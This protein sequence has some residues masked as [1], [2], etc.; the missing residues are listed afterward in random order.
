[1]CRLF[2]SSVRQCYYCCNPWILLYYFCT[3]KQKERKHIIFFNWQITFINLTPE[4]NSM[5][6]W[7]HVISDD[8][9]TSQRISLF[10]LRFGIQ[11]WIQLET[12]HPLS[13]CW[14]KGNS[15]KK[16]EFKP[17][18]M[19]GVSLIN[20]DRWYDTFVEPFT[21]RWFYIDI[22]E[23]VSHSFISVVRF[24][25]HF[26]PCWWPESSVNGWALN[27]GGFKEVSAL[28]AM[29][30]S[31]LFVERKDFSKVI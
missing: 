18:M 19:L 11:M 22:C 29:F 3:K 27:R 14:S 6:Q 31:Q 2:I 28:C 9:Q 17:F 21:C 1:M 8:F 15:Q 16:R 24:F 7:F 23:A 30:L 5:F 12:S 26:M 4:Q 10:W 20:F 13:K 25:F